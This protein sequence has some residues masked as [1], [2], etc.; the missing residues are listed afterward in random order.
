MMAKLI[1]KNK[2]KTTTTK[3][4]KKNKQT[5]KHKGEYMRAFQE[6]TVSSHKPLGERLNSDQLESTVWLWFK[7]AR[8]KKSPVSGL[9]TSARKIAEGPSVTYFKVQNSRRH[10]INFGT[11]CD[12]DDDRSD[13]GDAPFAW[14][15]NNCGHCSLCQIDVRQT[16]T[17]NFFSK[18]FFY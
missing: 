10:N 7:T 3:Q 5:T 2:T 1:F 18:P 12:N 17:T 11:G 13:T 9:K 14:Y 8:S 4:Q 16:N 15:I 6:N